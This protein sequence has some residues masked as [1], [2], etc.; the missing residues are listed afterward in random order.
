M[1]W[2]TMGSIWQYG[3]ITKICSCRNWEPIW[4]S[5]FFESFYSLELLEKVLKG[6]CSHWI[7]DAP[8]GEASYA[9]GR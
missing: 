2:Q 4:R 7:D 6:C 8:A 3:I 5:P 1:T 9:V